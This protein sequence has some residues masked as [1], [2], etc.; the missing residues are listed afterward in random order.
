MSSNQSSSWKSLLIFKSQT[1]IGIYTLENLIAV[2]VALWKV[3]LL[4]EIKVSTPSA[5]LGDLTYLA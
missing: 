5:I 1:Q 3:A 4:G 2:S